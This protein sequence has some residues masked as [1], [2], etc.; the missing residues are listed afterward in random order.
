MYGAIYSQ[1]RRMHAIFPISLVSGLSLTLLGVL[2][3]I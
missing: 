3:H 1:D 2:F